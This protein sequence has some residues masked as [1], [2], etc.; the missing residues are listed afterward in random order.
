MI[1]NIIVAELLT[2]T[3]ADAHIRTCLLTNEQI[4]DY[5]RKSIDLSQMF[6]FKN[7]VKRLIKNQFILIN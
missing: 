6:E 4:V 5:K 1:I 3:V 2:K 7:L